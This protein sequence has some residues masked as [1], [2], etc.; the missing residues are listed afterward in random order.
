MNAKVFDEKLLN[1]LYEVIDGYFNGLTASDCLRIVTSLDKARSRVN[2]TQR[3][4]YT[5]NLVIQHLHKPRVLRTATVDVAVD[6]AL[7]AAFRNDEELSIKYLKGLRAISTRRIKQRKSL[8]FRRKEFLEKPLSPAGLNTALHA[9]VK[10]QYRDKY[11]FEY[12]SSLIIK[13]KNKTHIPENIVTQIASSV[14]RLMVCNV[15]TSLICIKMAKRITSPNRMPNTMEIISKVY[16]T[17]NAFVDDFRS[18]VFTLYSSCNPDTMNLRE[19]QQCISSLSRVRVNKFPISCETVHKKLLVRVAINKEKYSATD[20]SVITKQLRDIHKSNPD[21]F[22]EVESIQNSSTKQTESS[23]TILFNIVTQHVDAKQWSGPVLEDAWDRLLYL[24]DPRTESELCYHIAT[25]VSVSVRTSQSC[26]PEMEMLT[27]LLGKQ[28]VIK[29]SNPH[30][31]L[32]YFRA[33]KKIKFSQKEIPSGVLTTLCNRLRAVWQQIVTTQ[34]PK[35]LNSL[36]DIEKY[37]PT[38]IVSLYCGSLVRIV[39]VKRGASASEIMMVLE[40][41]VRHHSKCQNLNTISE[42]KTILSQ[43]FSRLSD[44]L[45]D[46]EYC[47]L[48]KSL[49]I[50]RIDTHLTLLRFPKLL[51]K[52]GNKITLHRLSDIISCSTVGIGDSALSYINLIVRHSCKLFSES[53]ISKSDNE[54]RQ[55]VRMLGTIIISGSRCSGLDY[56]LVSLYC[57]ALLKYT[58]IF[59]SI[60]LLTTLNALR[61]SCENLKRLPSAVETLTS[62]IRIQMRSFDRR[63]KDFEEL[64]FA[65]NRTVRSMKFSPDATK[66]LSSD[67]VTRKNVV[68]QVTNEPKKINKSKKIKFKLVADPLKTW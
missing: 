7:A 10:I 55:L 51:P 11:F 18:L 12:L 49:S 33:V 42:N 64:S 62:A 57:N 16:R 17:A 60:S 45:T 38:D 65:Y 9:M 30:D 59:D 21:Q 2:H 68:S 43:R 22:Q 6:I 19:L 14:S 37:L 48:V 25:A 58:S 4:F 52:F 26:I 67:I 46:S 5:T 8:L 27:I 35:I 53:T 31:L 20:Q 50:L 1:H 3:L 41:L 56:V 44:R 32:K 23:S 66:R 40:M 61:I 47:S 29:K 39:A 13:I 28:S 15:T 34:L 36:S 54:N 63:D 24:N